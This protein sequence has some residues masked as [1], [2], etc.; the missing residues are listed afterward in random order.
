M[1]IMALMLRTVPDFPIVIAANRDEY[2][3]R[4]ALGPRVLQHRPMIW[5]GAGSKGERFVAWC[6]CTW[7]GRGV[8]Q[9]A[10]ER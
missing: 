7:T 3:S 9:P 4:S 5:G 1:C 2:Y 10:A 8:N 6:Q